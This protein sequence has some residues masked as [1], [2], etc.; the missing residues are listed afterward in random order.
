MTVCHNHALAVIGISQSG[1]TV[2]LLP[3]EHWVCVYLVCVAGMWKYV[4]IARKF[5]DVREFPLV[6]AVLNALVFA[7]A[8]NVISLN[9]HL[10]VPS[11]VVFVHDV[12][13]L[14]NVLAVFLA[15]WYL[16]A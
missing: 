12:R 9:M 10:V 14:L 5:P 15:V 3:Q 7:V 11:R 2:I 13:L 1:V 16:R 4:G 6:V 8:R